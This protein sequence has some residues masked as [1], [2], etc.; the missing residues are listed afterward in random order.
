[1]PGMGRRLSR[2]TLGKYFSEGA[3][4]LWS[5]IDRLGW[6]QAELAEKLETSSGQ[7]SQWL[8]GGRRPSLPW[9]LKIE[10]LVEIDVATWHQEPSVSFTPPGRDE[11]SPELEGADDTGEHPAATGTS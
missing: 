5:A 6:S 4:L 1:M 11:S 8:Y 7:V 2:P 9:A 10:K 3:R